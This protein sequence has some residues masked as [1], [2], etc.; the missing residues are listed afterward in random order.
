MK[1]EEFIERMAA[2]GTCENDAE[3]RN[4]ITALNTEVSADYDRI[5]TLSQQNTQL[6]DDNKRLTEYNMQMFL[7]VTQQKNPEETK[8][9]ET[10]IDNKHE[11]TKRTFDSLFN[12][13]GEIK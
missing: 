1:K 7:K 3:R 5:D 8:K 10:G 13:K 11:E 9:D 4:L 12:E 2:I 6:S